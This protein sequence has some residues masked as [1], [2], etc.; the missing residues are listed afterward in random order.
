MQIKKNLIG[1]IKHMWWAA[2]SYNFRVNFKY[3]FSAIYKLNTF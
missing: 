2:K 3:E 1:S